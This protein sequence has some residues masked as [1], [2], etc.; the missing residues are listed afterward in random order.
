MKILELFST[1]KSCRLLVNLEGILVDKYNYFKEFLSQNYQALSLL[2]ELEQIYYTGAPFSMGVVEK[3]CRDLLGCVRRLS[4]ELDGL[5]G[6]KYGDLIFVLERLER[7]LAPLYYPAPYCL[8]GDLVLPFS[9]LTPESF[10]DAGGKATHLAILANQL[11]LPIPPGFVVTACAFGRFLEENGLSQ[12]IEDSLAGVSPEALPDLEIKSQAIQE[13]ILGSPVPGHLAAKIT[14]GFAA[15]EAGAEKPLRLA[16]R[17]SAVGEDSQA[18]FAGQYHTCLNVTRENLLTAYKEVVASKYSPRAILYRLRYGLDDRDTPMGVAGVAMVDARTS[19]VLYTVDPARPDS[20]FLKISALWGLGEHLVSGEASADEF[21]VDRLTLTIRERHIS[22]K[23]QQLLNLPEGGLIL[24]E[25]PELEKTQPSL[26]DDQVSRLAQTGLLLEEYFQTPQDVE[27]AIDQQGQLFF[28]QSRPL[29]LLRSKSPQTAAPPE[30]SGYPVRLAAGKTA[31]PGIA[32]GRVF[33]PGSPGSEVLPDKAIL[34]TKTA[35]PEHASLMG[36]ISGIITDV[37]SITSHLASVAREL[38]VPAIF[39]TG[40]ATAVLTQG[41]PVTMVAETTT[42]Y[43]GLITELFPDSRPRRHHLADSPMHRRLRAVLEKLSPLNL[44]DPQSPA[45]APAGCQTV[46]DIIRF[47]HERSM[48]EMF[49]LGAVAKDEVISCKLTTHIPLSLYL[50]DL[51]GGIKTGLT[52][53]NEITP[54]HLESIPMRA[55]WRGLA[56]PGIN[57]SGGIP[58][59]TRDL[60]H[61]MTQG[62]MTRE[63]DLPGGD[64]FAIL[65]REYANLSAKFGY[66]Y[67]NIDALAGPND[68][69]NYF[70]LQFAGGVGSQHGRSLRLSFLGKVLGRLGCK[71]KVTGDLLEASLTG[72]DLKSMDATLEQ[73]GR[74]LAAS[75]LLDMAIT[76][77]G[78]VDRMV[79]AFFRGDYDFFHMAQERALPGFYTLTGDWLRVEEAG[80]SFIC[81]DGSSYAR[82][83]S[84]GLASLMG[85]MVGAKYQDFLDNVEAYYYFP[86]AVA[87][88][89]LAGN[90]NLSVRTKTVAGKIDQAG[91]LAFAIRDVANYFVLRVNALEDNFTLFEYVNNKRVQRANITHPINTGQWYQITVTISGEVL[92]GYL[93]GELLLEYQAARPLHGFVGLWTKADSVSYFDDLIVK[94]NGQTRRWDIGNHD[95]RIATGD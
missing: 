85:K 31:A 14:A 82:G 58:V 64:S 16:M 29:G 43:Q 23:E 89:S 45:F 62:M 5:G 87:R 78:D 91:G 46:H 19:G 50:I 8:A 4:Q 57:W 86:L 49:G 26:S 61:L 27:W 84:S 1:K 88:D 37:G 15:L 17:S 40:N 83:L 38:G 28:L 60:L 72:Y 24:E 34:V 95:S 52:T 56:H 35:S 32:A 13:M 20:G 36:R 55:L 71:L 75:R 22:R 90:A 51:G 41:E 2:A 76:G 12:A 21:L 69:E 94:A 79:E 66:H 63:S 39:A 47:A 67:A 7:E 73:V 80:R 59:G 53:C 42:I 10:P 6:G 70:S 3:H 68:D 54:E 65:S 93:D 74:L 44:T 30:F 48:Q 11:A 77:E 92:K 9:G 18:S 25:V 81:Q 33:M